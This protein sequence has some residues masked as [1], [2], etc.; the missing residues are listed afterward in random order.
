MH[1]WLW[2]ALRLEFSLTPRGPL[3]I[4]AGMTSPDPSLPDMQFVRTMTR[5]G[6]TIFVPGSSLKGVFRSF[7]EKVLRTHDRACDPFD[8]ERACGKKLQ[9]EEDT[10]TLYR[11]SCRACKIY[12]NTRLRGRMAFADLFPEG[13]LKTETRFGVAISRLTNAVAHGPFDMEI[14]VEG[15]FRGS[16]R[17]GNFEVWQLGLLAVTLQAVNDGLVRVGFGKNRGFGEVKIA[18]TAVTIDCCRPDVPADE[19]WG[20]GRLVPERER[21]RY[22]LQEDDSLSGLP[23]ATDE[24]SMGAFVRRC[25]DPAGWEAIAERSLER[26]SQVLGV[27]T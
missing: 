3:L 4:K 9:E 6:H 23:A 22:G 27:A 16:L 7:T 17:L 1:K 14:V 19:L 26:L 10:A 15:S 8:R 21:R 13:Q 5:Q 20:T 24:V 2:N 11:E 25:Y 12:G 18:P